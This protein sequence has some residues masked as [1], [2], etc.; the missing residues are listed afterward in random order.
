MK[1]V[2]LN[3]FEKVEQL[4]VALEGKAKLTYEE[5]QQLDRLYQELENLNIN[6]CISY[7]R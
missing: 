5:K 3:R 6:S 4:I 7:R 1:Q 2:N